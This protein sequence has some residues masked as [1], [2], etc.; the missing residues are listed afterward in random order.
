MG[1]A[2]RGLTV[3]GRTVAVSG[4]AVLFLA[5]L[6]GQHD[7]LSV[8]I[9]AIALPLVCAALIVRTRYRLTCARG[10]G[11]PRLAVGTS[12]T[13]LVRL[14]NSSNFAS[15]LL[16]VE[17]AV[18]DSLGTTSRIVIDRLESGGRRDLGTALTGTARGRYT[19]GPVQLT[20]RDPFGLCEVR[21]SFTATD[22]VIVTPHVVPLPPSTLAGMWGGRGDSEARSIAHSGDDDVI[23]RMYRTG[24]ELRRVHWRAT[25]RA[26]ELMVRREEQPWRTTATILLDR[27]ASSHRGTF[28]DSSFET[29]VS[30]AASAALNLIRHGLQVRVVDTDALTIAHCE[31][32]GDAEGVLL[33]SLAVVE[34]S[35][36]PAHRSGRNRTLSDSAALRRA[37]SDGT[38]L[39]IVSDLTPADAQ[40]LGSL[41]GAGGVA[42]C[43]I[44]DPLSWSTDSLLTPA[45]M[46]AALLSSHGWRSAVLSP[47]RLLNDSV[48]RR[49]DDD[50]RLV[51]AWEALS[52]PL[53]SGVLR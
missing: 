47:D 16:L 23:P 50:A 30:A 51:A 7:L 25:A 22:T 48:L 27:R 32:D 4:I 12:T 43:L 44:I 2:L 45:P 14:E 29:A 46:S 21:R 10:V 35:G 17:D 9:L 53:A 41:R 20:L 49:A 33:D 39:A 24:D 34:V 18:P 38:L 40:I 6:L 52:L 5:W 3:R 31:P 13:A 28:P 8:G 37:I 36:D 1:E 26:G 15:G 19:V 42:A 11:S